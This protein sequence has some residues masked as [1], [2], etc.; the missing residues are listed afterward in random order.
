MLRLNVAEL[1]CSRTK[2]VQRRSTLTSY[3][4]IAQIS[5]CSNLG[6]SDSIYLRLRVTEVNLGDSRED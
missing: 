4:F 3:E 1:L 5:L 6:V 2:H